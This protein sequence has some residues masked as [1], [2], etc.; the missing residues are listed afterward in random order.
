MTRFRKWLVWAGSAFALLVALNFG[1]S[2]IVGSRKVSRLLTADLESSFGRPVEVGH[3]GFSLWNGPQIEADSVTVGDDP[4]F[5]NEYFLRAGQL[6]ASLR[7]GSLLLG[8]VNFGSFS[9]SG[10][11]LNVVTVHGQWNLA[12]WLPAPSTSSSP[13]GPSRAKRLYRID[14]NNS[15]INFKRGIVKLPFALIDVNGS[16]NETSPG[17]WSISLAAQ[18]LRA[19]VTLQDAGTIQLDG[20]V[21]GTSARLRPARL[22]LRWDDASIADVLRLFFGYD[23]GVRGRQDL[24]LLASST[25]KGWRFQLDGRDSGLHSWALAAETENP[26]VNVRLEGIWFPGEGTLKLARGEISGPRS[27]ISLT[28]GL[29]WPVANPASGKPAAQ[30]PR[31]QLHLSSKGVAARDLLAWYRSFHE[32]IPTR[33]R[34]GG[35]LRGT[36]SIGGWPPRVEQ[37]SIEAIGM[38]ASGGALTKPVKLGV[39]TLH[40][41]ERGAT[42]SL[43]NLNFGSK[44]GRFQITGRARHLRRWDYRLEATGSSGQVGHLVGAVQALGIRVPAYWSEFSGGAAIKV[45]WTGTVPSSQRTVVASIDLKNAIWREPSLPAR[46]RL[47]N[48]RLEATGTQLRLDIRSARALGASWHGWL[49]RR[50]ATG[51]WQFTLEG[52]SLNGQTLLA[53]L[54]PQP[55]R[56]S[57]LERIFGFGHAAGS[58]PLWPASLDASGTIRLGRLSMVPLDL[59]DVRGRIVIHQGTL[60]FSPAQA[61]FYGGGVRGTFFF[62]VEKGVPVWRL[63]TQ[64]SAVNLAALS[65]AYGRTDRNRFS[66]WAS[67]NLDLAARVPTIPSWIDSLRGQAQLS[68]LDARDAGINWLSTLEAGHAVSGRSA[69]RRCSVQIQL[70]A[71]KLTLQNLS[72]LSGR[73]RLEATGGIDLSHGGALSVHA[74]Y[75]PVAGFAPGR[76]KLEERTYEVTGSSSKPFIRFMPSSAESKDPSPSR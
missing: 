52:N 10:A 58:P 60:E 19:A 64:V 21:G 69:F 45:D 6:S 49:E 26:Y 24:N 4:R 51:A 68:I 31:L 63:R 59:N 66:G 72:A 62:A 42:L 27:S 12:D 30:V 47:E 3:F 23:Y 70:A 15:R 76:T 20:E 54:R 61:R 55:Q 2:M 33:L 74:R 9:F 50:K 56:P 5:G 16:V 37:A 13:K 22:H 34:A 11:S 28:G 73:G 41:S 29:D 53:R 43:S 39:G 40:V 7:L 48:A 18:P 35:L 57:L 8:R 1:V 75:F 17:R 38:N 32:A 25:G 46:V 65:R 44:V 67:G 71:G 14:I 36:A